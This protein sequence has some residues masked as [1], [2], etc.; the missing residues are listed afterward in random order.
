MNCLKISV[1]SDESMQNLGRSIAG[2]LEK[3]D[4]LYISG[5]LGAGKT[6]LVRGIAR[7]LGFSGRVS[8]PTFTIMNIYPGSPELY[9]FDLYR[10]QDSD[11]DDLGW[12]DYLE[13][14]G[15]SLIEWPRAG[16]SVFPG[17]ALFINIDLCDDDYDRERMV[18]ISAEGER[19]RRKLEE[20]KRI[21][22]TGG[23]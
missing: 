11:L 9:H 17:E 23:R 8:S 10:L 13:K 18:S 15:V 7:G 6:T 5:E 2:L 1:P 12:E 16:E 3:G 14:E 22:N 20:L 4:V 19:Y 21:V